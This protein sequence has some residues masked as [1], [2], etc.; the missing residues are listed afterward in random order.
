MLSNSINILDATLIYLY[1][2]KSEF[3]DDINIGC[4]KE[5]DQKKAIKLIIK[6]IK[7]VLDY[8]T[9]MSNFLQL[10]VFWQQLM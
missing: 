3:L 10:K 2:P 7:F 1:N 6:N 8:Q 4:L 5:N 9:M